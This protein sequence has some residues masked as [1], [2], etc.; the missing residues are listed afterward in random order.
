M[1]AVI[2]A[3]GL[4][5][6]LKPLTYKVPKP[7]VE[8]GGKPF[9]EYLVLYLKKFDI[10]DIV[11]LTGYMSEKIMDY[12]SGASGLGVSIRYSN[13]DLPLGTGGALKN[14]ES[15]L[16]G[17]FMVI[18]GDT[19]LPVDYVKLIA[20]YRRLNGDSLI[21][22]NKNAYGKGNISMGHNN[23]V[24]NY[25][26]VAKNLAYND[27]GLQF[28]SRKILDVIPRNKIIS[29]ENDIFP[30]LIRQKRLKGYDVC[31]EFFDIGSFEGIEKFRAK[32][33]VF[34]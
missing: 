10:N 13:E 7:M 26:K 16:K 24:L 33:E 22:V 5:T 19:F 29:L 8:I 34:F 2:L 4:G 3:G 31:R 20:H 6:R 28:F 15:F 25:D 1:Q 30:V 23:I 17:E 12:F 9:L 27:C 14:A 32:L 18:N 21:I 11:I